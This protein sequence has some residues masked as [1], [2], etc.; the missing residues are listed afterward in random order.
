MDTWLSFVMTIFDAVL[1]MVKKQQ[2]NKQTKKTYLILGLYAAP[3]FT[4]YLRCAILAPVSL[5]Y[6]P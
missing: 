5:R 4:V 6:S 1:Y 3:Q 2:Q